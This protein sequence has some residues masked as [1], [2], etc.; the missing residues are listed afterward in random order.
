[1]PRTGDALLTPTL[2][3]HRPRD[4]T[5]SIERPP[6]RTGSLVYGAILGGPLALLILALFDAGRLRAPAG[7]AQRIAAVCVACLVAS[8]TVARL[9]GLDAGGRLV[10]GLF[11]LLAFVPVRRS[12]LPADR[13]RA[14]YAP[15]DDEAVVYESIFAVTVGVVFFSLLVT[16]LLD[17]IVGE[18]L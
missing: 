15:D 9:L 11:G 13:I 16:V 7:T 6:W 1:M 4:Y 8:V 2:T 3:D 14:M 12:L 17:A 18:V 10:V 5:G